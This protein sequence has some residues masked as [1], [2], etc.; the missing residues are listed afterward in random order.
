VVYF[1]A[2]GI[3]VFLAG[4]AVL[5]VMGW[6]TLQRVKAL[7]RSV[8]EASERIAEVSAALEDIR[9]VQPR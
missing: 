9:P 6:R 8:A 4:V 7:G 1:A 2:A 5:A 3:L